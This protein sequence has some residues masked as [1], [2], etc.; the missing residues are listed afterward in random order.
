MSFVGYLDDNWALI[1]LLVALAILN[2]TTVHFSKRVVFSVFFAIGLI[3]VLSVVE[4]IEVWLGQQATYSIWRAILTALKYSIPPFLLVQIGIFVFRQKIYIFLPAVVLLIL[5]LISVPTGIVFYFTEDNV[6]VRGVLGY[7]PFIVDGLYVAYLV[8]LT[9][10]QSS[11]TARDLIPTIFLAVTIVAILILSILADGFDKRFCTAIAIDTLV[12][13][14][15]YLQQV[16]KTDPLTTLLNRQSYYSDISRSRM[17]IFAVVSI[18]MNGLKILNDTQGHLAGDKALATIA[19][20]ISSSLRFRQR[21]Y[22]IGGDEFAALC[23]QDNETEVRALVAR[24][25]SAIAMT[26]YSISIGYA[27]VDPKG[28]VDEAFAKA[29]AVMYEEKKRYKRIHEAEIGP[30]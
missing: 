21:A 1:L 7:L 11:K 28:A 3:A 13:F 22:R 6:F 23:L 25:R 18:D 24:I 29:D 20:A 15:F 14:L 4:Y 9:L 16:T 27:I 5:C 19:E 8:F 26:P 17:D 2:L 10:R 30:R 12:Y